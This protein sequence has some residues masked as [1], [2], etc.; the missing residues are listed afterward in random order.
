MLDEK[1]E[2]E[3]RE[4]FILC[5]LGEKLAERNIKEK[6]RKKTKGKRKRKERRREEGRPAVGGRG[7][8]LCSQGRKGRRTT[9]S[10]HG[11]LRAAVVTSAI[12]FAR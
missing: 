6:E 12:G 4:E 7:R 5:I 3:E 8:E 2:R 9:V 1:I 10:H 11:Q